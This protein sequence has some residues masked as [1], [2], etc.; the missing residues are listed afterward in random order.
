[1]TNL[2]PVLWSAWGVVVIAFAV[3]YVYRESLTR[4]E[5]DQVFLD[6]SFDQQKIAQAAIVDR[7]NKIQPAL[8]V[9]L[10]LSAAMTAV[11]IV[12]YIFDMLAQFK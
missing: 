10:W 12:Y 9:T 7:V 8:R 5:D 4:D 11:V 2:V 6:E 3:L 1:M